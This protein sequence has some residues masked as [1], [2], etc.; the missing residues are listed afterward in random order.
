MGEASLF[1]TMQALPVFHA[2]DP[3]LLKRLASASSVRSVTARGQIVDAYDPVSAVLVVLRGMAEVSLPSEDG[4]LA[5]I[6]FLVP[7]HLA[8]DAAVLDRGPYGVTLAGGP[9]CDVLRV[10]P[11]AFVH[12]MR[13]ST[14]L[15]FNVAVALSRRLRM[16]FRRQEWMQMR[17][18]SRRLASF[19]IW[20]DAQREPGKPSLRIT[21]EQLGALVGVSRETANKCLRRWVQAGLLEQRAGSIAVIDPPRLMATA[22]DDV[23][24]D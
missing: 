19:L 22:E 15:A 18:V 16:M 3:M 20:L 8:G 5:L 4:R 2:V 17:S 24:G 11:A 1:E 13:E 6:G 12:A 9:D 7:G 10:E 14:T 23:T 21:Q